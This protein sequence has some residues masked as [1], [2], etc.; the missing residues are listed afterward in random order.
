MKVMHSRTTI[1]VLGHMN[2]A[3]HHPKWYEW[4]GLIPKEEAEEA[5][6][7]NPITTRLTSQFTS[8][9]RTVTCQEGR[10]EV[11]SDGDGS[12]ERCLELAAK[13]F[14]RLNDTPVTA[15]GF[16]IQRHL[17][18]AVANVKEALARTYKEAGIPLLEGELS[19]AKCSLKIEVPTDK[20]TTRLTIEPSIRADHVVYV[21]SNSEYIIDEEDGHFDLKKYLDA[22]YKY[23]L[24][25]ADKRG[26]EVVG[27]FKKKQG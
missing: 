12:G 26:Q 22:E 5:L 9:K 23:A 14:E 17:E 1:V 7:K 18:T 6:R 19:S 4:V 13:V 8:S 25:L 20:R 24:E 3:I 16:N 21:H 27:L 2:P 15:V 11:W 10:W